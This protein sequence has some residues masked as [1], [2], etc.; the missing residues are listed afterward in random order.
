MRLKTVLFLVLILS[1]GTRAGYSRQ[2]DESSESSAPGQSFDPSSAVQAQTPQPQL[3]P[4]FPLDAETQQY[5]EQ[6]LAYWEGTSAQVSHYQCK[7]TRWQ[8][9]P[10]LCSYR[11]PDTNHLVAAMISFGSIRFSSPGKGMYEVD[12]KF[13]FA[14]PPDQPGEDPKY[15]RRALTNPEFPEKE[16]WICDGLA[17]Y[18]Y[19]YETKRLYETKLPPEAQGEGLKNSPLP[20]VFGAKATELLDRYWIRDVTP[21]NA[22]DQYWLEAWPKRLSDAQTYSKIE[23]MLSRDPFLPYAIHMYAPNYDA[24][25]NPSKMSFEFRERQING[26]LAGLLDHFFIRPSTPPFWQRVE[27]D[28]ASESFPGDVPRVSESLAPADPNR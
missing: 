12:E 2:T 20:F 25:T 22:Q 18:E 13:S 9:D 24:K 6:L 23:I 3:P 26:T 21:G 8:F 14:S 17:I 7:F 4:G 16:K 10:E 1:F 28:L 27:N 15:E 5:I 19:D 11:K